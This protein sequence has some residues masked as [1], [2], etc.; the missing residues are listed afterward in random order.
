MDK[1]D[2]G[3]LLAMVL[4]APHLNSTWACVAGVIFIIGGH[5][6]AFSERKLK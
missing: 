4:L 2:V 6:V 5:V 1:G 3:T